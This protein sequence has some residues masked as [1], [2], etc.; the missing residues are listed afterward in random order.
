MNPVKVAAY[1]LLVILI[2]LQYPL[3]FGDGGVIAVWRL[4]REIAAQQKENALLKDRNQ[5][6]EAQV[7]DLKQGLEV[8]EGRARSELG[9]VKK[10]EVFI[11]VIEQ[12]RDKTPTMGK[13]PKP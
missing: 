6:L 9:M 5:T 8:I 7:N 1:V 2:L 10:G 13:E 12:P 11:Q 3:W 4:D